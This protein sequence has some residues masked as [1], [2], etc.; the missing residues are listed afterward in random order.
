[1]PGK[2]F[3]RERRKVKDGEKKPRYRVVAVADCDMKI[4]TDHLR[5]SELQHLSE[6]VG[7]E[8][9]VLRKGPKHDKPE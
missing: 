8:L 6:A 3:Y 2:I 1:M 7:A 5:L 9:I 4:Y